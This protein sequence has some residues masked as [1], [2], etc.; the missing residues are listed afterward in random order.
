MKT[1]HETIK[2]HNVIWKTEQNGNHIQRPD[3]IRHY[4]YFIIV[5]VYVC[6]SLNVRVLF[7]SKQYRI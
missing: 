1:K 7:M 4:R 5:G 6:V 2:E 3:K